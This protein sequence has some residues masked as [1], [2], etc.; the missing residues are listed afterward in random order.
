MNIFPDG[1]HAA[2]LERDAWQGRIAVSQER[3]NPQGWDSVQ[4]AISEWQQ[5][6]IGGGIVSTTEAWR[7]S[8][9]VRPSISMFAGALASRAFELYK[10]DTEVEQHWLLDLIARPNPTLRLSEFDL[11]YQTFSIYELFGECFWFLEYGD[12]P[13]PKNGRRSAKAVPSAIWVYHPHAVTEVYNLANA[14]EFLGWQVYFENQQF[15]VDKNDAIH[16]R[17]YDPTRHNPLR[18]SRGTSPYGSKM[19]AISS[20]LAASRFN[21]DFFS[22]GVAP[23]VVFMNKG[24]IQEKKEGEFVERLKA[25]VAGKNS[26]PLVLDNGEWDVKQLAS[27]QKDAEFTT[28]K[29][30]ARAETLGGLTPPVAV[31]KDDASYANAEVQTKIWWTY[32]LKPTIRAWCEAIDSVVFAN[33]PQF[34]TD[35][36]T[37]DVPE[38]QADER[39]RFKMALEAVG[40]R[41]PWTVAAKMFDLKVERFKGD[42]IAMCSFSDVPVDDILAGRDTRLNVAPAEDA[43]GT[44][45]PAESAQPKDTAP[46]VQPTDGEPARTIV[47]LAPSKA[48]M[49]ITLAHSKRTISSAGED[50]LRTIFSIIQG[51]DGKLRTLAQR[52]QLQA[53]EA[54]ARQIGSLIGVDALVSIDNPK[55]TEFLA[56]R[57]NLITSVNGTTA[58]NINEAIR[59]LMD[60]GASPEDIG[61]AIRNEFNL[62]D[63]QSKLISRTEV[64]SGLNGGRQ[65]QMIES[66]ITRE[67]W[68]TSR[69]DRVR[70][71]HVA[72]DGEV[73]EVGQTFSNGCRYPQDPTG[74]PSETI[75]CRCIAL[76]VTS[77]RASRIADRAGYWRASVKNVRTVETA[78]QSALT[79]YFTDQRA[80]VL[81]AA[82]AAGIAA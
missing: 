37:K 17:H 33:D 31:G 61:R 73:I 16:F 51:D 18:P 8:P 52:F 40:K 70:E 21:L 64:G 76:P 35:L 6:T 77:D 65:I 67:E 44:T 20:D 32:R 66:G 79:R 63:K 38:L 9:W 62:R 15:F 3:A 7:S 30:Q 25:K 56:A 14:R 69:D 28:G 4:R 57:G 72:I 11:K 45:T 81:K 46:A 75:Q 60:E 58:D 36:S 55:I 50:A 53:I 82:A 43:S 27:M 22:R 49:R 23:N 13:A 24:E 54:G 59:E 78:M 48:D 34:W 5:F 29:E 10:G 39:E 74:D 26:E 2:S 80:R 47:R 71:S 41:M 42:D 68:L 1:V 12:A 19:L